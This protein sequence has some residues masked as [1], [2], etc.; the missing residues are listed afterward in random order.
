M[1]ESMNMEKAVSVCFNSNVEN[2]FCDNPKTLQYKLD[3]LNEWNSIISYLLLYS[4]N[5]YVQCVR[6]F[7]V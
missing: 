2:E 1:E 6:T 3:I 7:G 5:P 4:P